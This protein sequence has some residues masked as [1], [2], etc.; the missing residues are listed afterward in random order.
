VKAKLSDLAVASKPVPGRL[1]PDLV[2]GAHVQWV[3]PDRDL[4]S[5]AAAAAQAGAG[6]GCR[7]AGCGYRYGC[8]PIQTTLQL[9]N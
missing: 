4:N 9:A 5:A 3:P 1:N 6:A 2:R 8:E 7:L